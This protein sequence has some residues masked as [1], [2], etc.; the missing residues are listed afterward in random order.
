MSA[1]DVMFVGAVIVAV[2]IGA[3]TSAS[4]GWLAFGVMLIFIVISG[5]GH[6]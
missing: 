6:E 3:L 2:S 1:V 5:D 4:W